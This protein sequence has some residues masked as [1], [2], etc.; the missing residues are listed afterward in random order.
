MKRGVNLGGWL[1]LEKWITPSVFG[2]YEA[3]DEYVLCKQLSAEAESIL[4]IHRDNFITEADF[5]WIAEH[6]LDAVRLPLGYWIFGGEKPFVGGIEYVDKAFEWA[7]RYG[8]GILLDL[9]G[10]PGSQ[11]GRD[12]S[13]KIGNIN[14]NTLQNVS[15]SLEI[16]D[17]LASRYKGHNN[18]V[19]IELLNEPVKISQRRYL[20]DYYEH[21]YDL[22][23]QYCGTEVCVVASDAFRPKRWGRIMQ[24]SKYQNKQ[25]D[26]HMYQLFTN[27]DKKL[28]LEGHI[29]K[30]NHEWRKLIERVGKTWPV[31]I[32]EWSLALDEPTLKG[33]SDDV[34]AAAMRAYGSV[35]LE[36]FEQAA[37]WFYWTYR[38]EGGGAWSYRHCVE[39]GWLPE[40][41][42]SV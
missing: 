13:G 15:K 3:E 10:A 14:W 8:L 29:E 19:G 5:K 2:G 37:S 39:H 41:Y 40:K 20:K 11:N 26:V 23:R 42:T 36:V 4:K 27:A 12:H 16:I 17:R 21:G 35:Q 34:K 31:M 18:L 24:D 9:H 7:K 38:T 32:G 25:L 6:G 30:A 1:V 28:S 22:V 33:L